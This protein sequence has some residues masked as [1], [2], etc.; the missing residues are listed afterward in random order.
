M[1]VTLKGQLLSV[2][3]PRLKY[4]LYNFMVS[5]ELIQICKYR[6]FLS[7]QEKLNIM[8]CYIFQQILKIFVILDTNVI[9]LLI[10]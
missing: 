9:T 1:G 5:S 8:H 3:S 7:N 2:G 6:D 10:H 4:N